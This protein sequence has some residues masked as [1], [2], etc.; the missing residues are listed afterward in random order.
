MVVLLMQQP[1][2]DFAAW[3][4]VFNSNAGLRK[5]Y[6]GISSQVYQDISDPNAVTVV[7]K[8]DSLENAQKFSGSPELKTAQQNA[9]VEGQP[10]VSF[11]TEA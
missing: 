11:L 6:G 1:V 9:G 5:S 2:N 7:L 4:E 8:W 3:K 10:V